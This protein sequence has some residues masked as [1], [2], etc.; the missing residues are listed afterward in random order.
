[1]RLFGKL[2]QGSMSWRILG[3][4]N[5]MSV[6]NLSLFEIVKLKLLFLIVYFH[7]NL[8]IGNILLF[9]VMWDNQALYFLST[10]LNFVDALPLKKI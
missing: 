6:Y 7:L 2:E 10:C 3:V 9:V 5:Y 4:S 1:M 8:L